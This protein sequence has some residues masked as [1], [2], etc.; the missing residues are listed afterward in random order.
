MEVKDKMF[1]PQ[2]KV[3]VKSEN[4]FKILKKEKSRTKPGK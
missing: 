1:V 4:K 2:S 3:R